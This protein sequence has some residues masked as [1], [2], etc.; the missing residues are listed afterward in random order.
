[1]I[2]PVMQE[3]STGIDWW[4]VAG[5]MVALSM[6]VLLLI[7]GYAYYSSEKRK[8][9]S[10]A[11]NDLADTRGKRIE[12]LEDEITRMRE[13]MQNQQGQIDMLRAFKTQEIISGVVEG[14]RNRGVE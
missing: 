12:D 14:L 2:E 3:V 8:V 1:M 11:S 13:Q 10:K 4:Q 6:L 9:A 5:F 7:G